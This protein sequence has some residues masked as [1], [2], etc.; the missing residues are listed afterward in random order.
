MSIHF[1]T[2]INNNNTGLEQLEFPIPRCIKPINQNFLSL[3][4]GKK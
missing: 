2:K 4:R 3:F 1:N